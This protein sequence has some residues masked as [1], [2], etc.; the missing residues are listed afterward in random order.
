MKIPKLFGKE[1]SVA[2]FNIKR[3]RSPSILGRQ[4]SFHATKAEP[5]LLVSPVHKKFLQMMVIL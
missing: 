4:R 1:A 3:P 5:F 2:G